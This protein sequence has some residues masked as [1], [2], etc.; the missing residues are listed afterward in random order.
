MSKKR[1]KQKTQTEPKT[2]NQSKDTK[3]PQ[4]SAGRKGKA[5]GKRKIVLLLIVA[6][7]VLILAYLNSG[8][9]DRLSQLV[10]NSD[11]VEIGGR[12]YVAAT[13]AIVRESGNVDS[14]S[15]AFRPEDKIIPEIRSKA[16]ESKSLIGEKKVATS[17][18]V[19]C[20]GK[21]LEPELD[22]GYV[23]YFE[24]GKIRFKRTYAEIGL[25]PDK[26]VMI[27]PESEEASSSICPNVSEK[28]GLALEKILEIE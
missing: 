7:L 21:E 8:E 26:I 4:S 19:L 22:Y 16:T 6:L 3:K 27:E 28:I 10:S 11:R 1:N 5:L 9:V 13:M 24:D 2:P 25:A 20:G 12:P 14:L 23:Y 15:I 17:L 18:V